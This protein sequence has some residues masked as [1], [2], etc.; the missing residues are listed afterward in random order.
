MK[1]YQEYLAKKGMSS[2]TQQRQIAHIKGFLKWLKAQNYIV[3]KLGYQ[4]MI[5]YL[6]AQRQKGIGENTLVHYLR[7]LYIYFDY[8]MAYE[9]IQKHPLQHLQLRNQI[10]QRSQQ[11]SLENLLEEEELN[12][13]YSV[14]RANTRLNKKHLNMLGLMVY[15]GIAAEETKYLKAKHL[16][17]EQTRIFV[18]SSRKHEQ[19]YLSL[20]AVQI[21]ALSQ[22]I[23]DKKPEALLFEYTSSKQAT[24]SR[25]WLSTQIKRELRRN[26]KR[27]IKFKNLSQLRTSRIS[28]WVSSLGLRK[29][30]Y[31]AG[32]RHI[33]STQ[34]YKVTDISALQQQIKQFHP[35]K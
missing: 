11:K 27:A 9:A 13:I 23:T 30:Q 32:H 7:Y 33:A 28:L 10:K 29:A 31:L 5:H 19:R 21:L 18:P 34:S 24:N 2:S 22:Y 26:N 17:L 8:L 15:Q 16:D 1:L 12:S 25:S 3:E 14:Y 4:E 35:L 6:E 20:N